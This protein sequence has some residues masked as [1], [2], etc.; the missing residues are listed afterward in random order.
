MSVVE[1]VVCALAALWCAAAAG[2]LA[3]GRRLVLLSALPVG[4]VARAQSK[5]PTAD[6]HKT[7]QTGRS[8]PGDDSKDI[9]GGCTASDADAWS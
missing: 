6:E 8:T 2:C 3:G 7:R 5:G 1:S 4:G 9:Q